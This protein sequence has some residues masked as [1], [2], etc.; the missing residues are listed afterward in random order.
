MLTDIKGEIHTNAVIAGD[1]YLFVCLF[2]AVL[3]PHCCTWSFF[4]CDEWGLLFVVVHGLLTAVA[5][6]AVE[7]RL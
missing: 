5:F 3:G 4:S 7:H 2:M 1:I 6:L